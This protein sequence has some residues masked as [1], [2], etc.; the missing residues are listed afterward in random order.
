[1]LDILVRPDM[2]AHGREKIFIGRQ[3]ENLA[4]RVKFDIS[5]WRKLYGDGSAAL[6]HRRPGDKYPYPCTVVASTD[7]GCFYWEV[8]KADVSVFG[9][10]ELQLRYYVDNA[11]VKSQIWDSKIDES[12]DYPLGTKPDDLIEDWIDRVAQAAQEEVDKH[13]PTCAVT[14]ITGG[15]RVTITDINKSQSFN[16]MDGSTGNNGTDGKDGVSPTIVVTD[17]SGGHRVTITDATG[18]TT[19]DVMDGT[20]DISEAV[21]AVIEEAKPFVVTIVQTNTPE[22]KKTYTADKTYAEIEAAINAGKHCYVNLTNGSGSVLG[23]LTLST[24]ESDA[25]T[26]T[27]LMGGDG[28]GTT[29][30]ILF[31]GSDNKIFVDLMDVQQSITAIGLLKGSKDGTISAAEAGTDYVTPDGMNTAIQSAIQNTWEASY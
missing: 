3:G 16:V 27:A 26:F 21:K 18:T 12:L 30:G 17:V 22:G 8:T 28:A 23:M 14:E 13:L 9:V 19:F 24:I 1:M 20:Q 4:R 6:V 10:G 11:L 25:M 5:E 2:N 31:I 7:D 29:V 15:H